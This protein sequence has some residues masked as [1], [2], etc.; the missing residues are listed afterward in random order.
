MGLDAVAKGC[1]R[2]VSPSC[3]AAERSPCCESRIGSVQDVILL[4]DTLHSCQAI[5]KSTAHALAALEGVRSFTRSRHT[6]DFWSH[7]KNGHSLAEWTEF[8]INSAC[9]IHSSSPD[10]FVNNLLALEDNG[11]MNMQPLASTDFDCMSSPSTLYPSLSSHVIQ[12]SSKSSLPMPALEDAA[13]TTS[14]AT[15]DTTVATRPIYAIDNLT[16][17]DLYRVLRHAPPPPARVVPLG[18]GKYH[19][20]TEQDRAYILSFTKWALQLH[21]NIQLSEICKLMARAVCGIPVSPIFF[22]TKDLLYM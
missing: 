16:D 18:S 8:Y 12:A 9:N 21:P 4:L 3:A 13:S 11:G 6:A 7:Q 5:G 19:K 15:G 17:A 22:N 10:D 20:Y 1:Q 14:V 2:V